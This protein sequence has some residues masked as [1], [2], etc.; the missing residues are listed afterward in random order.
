MDWVVLTADTDGEKM[1][2]SLSSVSSFKSDR[3]YKTVVH[4]NAGNSFTVR[5]SWE[6][7]K[8]MLE[9]IYQ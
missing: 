3:G 8:T 5:E 9:G 4:M 6:K 1:I 2:V 7:I